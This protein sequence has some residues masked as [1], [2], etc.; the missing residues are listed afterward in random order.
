VVIIGAG[1]AGLTAG[2]YAARQGLRTAIVA[3]EVGGQA[4]WAGEIENYLGWRLVTGKELVHHF[5]EHVRQFGVDCYEGRL[6]NA[7][8]PQGDGYDLYTREGTVLSARAVIVATGRAPN[9]VAVPGEREL[10]GRG[11]SYCATCDA[12]FFR[13]QDVAVVGFG[14]SAAHAALELESLG[15]RVTL[16]TPSALKAA[17][18]LLEKV[19][20]S[21]SI[22]LRVG[23]IVTEVLGDTRVTGLKVKQRGSDDPET[24]A[25]TG[26]FVETGA[27][28]V[29]EFTGGILEQNARG[30]IIVDNRGATSA[31]GI[32][33]AGDVTDTPGKQIIIAAGEGARA[34]IAVAKELKR[35]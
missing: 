33:A 6:V 21:S 31:P 2:M 34:A 5:R 8:V 17:D 27:I 18:A 35:R 14:D 1:P 22:D 25:V 20:A 19:A 26:V 23:W 4:L 16:L 9:R 12:A 15:A 3:G 30:E 7:M 10:V 32:F 29:A 24:L 28:P 11:V 13:D